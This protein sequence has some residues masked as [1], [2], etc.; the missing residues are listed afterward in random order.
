ME[1]RIKDQSTRR[2]TLIPLSLCESY[3]NWTPKK[4]VGAVT[5]RSRYGE[6]LHIFPFQINF[7]SFGSEFNGWKNQ[8]TYNRIKFDVR[9]IIMVWNLSLTYFNMPARHELSIMFQRH[10][11]QFDFFKYKEWSAKDKEKWKREPEML[12]IKYGNCSLKFQFI[13]V[14]R[15]KTCKNVSWIHVIKD[16]NMR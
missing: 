2:S 4:A 3:D 11:R 14:G 12:V 8:I 15:F 13:H 6:F 9:W 7:L 10:R 5:P 16:S 1:N